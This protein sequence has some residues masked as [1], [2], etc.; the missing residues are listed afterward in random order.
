MENPKGFWLDLFLDWQDKSIFNTAH[1]PQSDIWQVYCGNRS[2]AAIVNQ[3]K[4][5]KKNAAYKEKDTSKKSNWLKNHDYMFL[6]ILHLQKK[7]SSI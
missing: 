2:K 6:I 5:K 1:F 4:K 7:K 3:Q